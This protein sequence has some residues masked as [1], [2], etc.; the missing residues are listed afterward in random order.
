ML[1][2]DPRHAT[3]FMAALSPHLRA[4]FGL[5]RWILGNDHDA[6]DVTQDAYMRAFRH[7]DAFTGKN[8]RAWLLAIVRR[9]CYT[10]LRLRRATPV[11]VFEEEEHSPANG[12]TYDRFDGPERAALRAGDARLLNDAVAA[13][14]VPYR[15]IFILRELEGLSYREIAEIADVPIGTVMSRLSRARA[16]LQQSLRDSG[17]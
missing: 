11:G 1:E 17:N 12:P 8:P 4:G 13:L 10:H 6:E 2:H 15:E 16:H 7:M 9:C 14:A 5:A 3:E